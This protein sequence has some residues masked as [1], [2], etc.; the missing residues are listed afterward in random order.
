M[1]QN[2]LPAEAERRMSS[3][4]QRRSILL[5][6][7]IHLFVFI[8][9]PTYTIGTLPTPPPPIIEIEH[10][11]EPPD[12]QEK[13]PVH[14]RPIIPYESDDDEDIPDDFEIAETV[15]EHSRWKSDAPPPILTGVS[16]ISK[17]YDVKPEPIHIVNPE[18]PDLARRGNISGTVYAELLIGTDGR[19]QKIRIVSG[20]DIFRKSVIN[21]VQ[22]M[23][24]KPAQSR[25]RP[26][27]VWITMPFRF[28]LHESS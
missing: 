17:S 1:R 26:V 6:L 9:A 2:H 20:P 22:D 5:A 12:E 10:V 4:F 11:Y 25:N 24:F 27:A 15:L 19:V 18:Y 14:P 21:A 23:V 16:R 13:Q 8:A 3:M 7:L 28:T